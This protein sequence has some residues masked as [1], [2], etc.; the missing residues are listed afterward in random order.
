MSDDAQQG[1]LERTPHDYEVL[2]EHFQ[3]QSDFA[4]KQML[5]AQ[6]VA[7][8]VRWHAGSDRLL[9]D[10]WHAIND[11]IDDYTAL[12]DISDRIAEHLDCAQL[13]CGGCSKASLYGDAG[14]GEALFI[15]RDWCQECEDKKHRRLLDTLGVTY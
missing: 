15:R 12:N 1:K 2:I 9:I 7:D 4:I 11:D 5:D 13:R 10:A 3:K 14:D 6:Q 8:R